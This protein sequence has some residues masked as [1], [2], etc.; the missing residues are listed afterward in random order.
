MTSSDWIKRLEDFFQNN[1]LDINWLENLENFCLRYDLNIKH[2]TEVLNDPKVIPM[3][4]GKSFE[5]TVKD[6]LSSILSEKYYVTNPRLNAQTGLND[7][8]VSIINKGN[9][10]KYSIECKLAS[11]GSFRIN[12][13]GDPFLKIKCMRSRTL[14]EEA[15]LQRSKVTGISFQALMIHNDQYTAKEFDLVITSIAN[16][17]FKTDS[18]GLFFWSPTL[19]AQFFLN[20]LGVRNQSEA[21]LKMYVAKS[22]NLAAS[23]INEV[24]CTRQ[25]CNDSNCNFIPNYPIIYFNRSSGQPLFPW[26]SLDKIESLLD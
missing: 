19:E 26:I 25:K 23:Q 8:D 7:I 3:I 21:F 20:N 9:Q 18:D 1:E 15:A 6:Y 22:K 17:F 13:L 5:F 12:L 4:R 2:L 14:G 10:K 11:K 16:S 24:R